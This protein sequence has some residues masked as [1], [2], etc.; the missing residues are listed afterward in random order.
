MPERSQT[1]GIGRKP[2]VS[3]VLLVTLPTSV[4]NPLFYALTVGFNCKD[5]THLQNGPA[6]GGRTW[7]PATDSPEDEES[8]DDDVDGHADDAFLD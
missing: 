5:E 7:S 1:R 3:S 4:V 2:N 8:H 6:S